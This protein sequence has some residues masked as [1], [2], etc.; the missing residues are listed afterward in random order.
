MR[1]IGTRVESGK[2]GATME[3]SALQSSFTKGDAWKVRIEKMAAHAT[4]NVQCTFFP[5]STL[6]NKRP[7]LWGSF[8]IIPERQ[9]ARKPSSSPVIGKPQVLRSFLDGAE[10][11]PNLLHCQTFV[12]RLPED[13]RV[14]L[15]YNDIS[16]S[17]TTCHQAQRS[18]ANGREVV[19]CDDDGTCVFAHQ[20][21]FNVPPV[22]VAPG[23]SKR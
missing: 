10:D 16:P 11:L 17:W 13:I 2:A 9:S 21:A 4:P 6:V 8:F 22:T 7:G 5:D 3:G 23:T 1:Y 18:T 19:L 20:I 12:I 14:A 15:V